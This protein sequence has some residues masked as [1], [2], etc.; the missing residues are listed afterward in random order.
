MFNYLEFYLRAF[1]FENVVTK[2]TVNASCD[3]QGFLYLTK[4]CANKTHKEHLFKMSF[5]TRVLCL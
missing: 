1:N 3:K 4:L 2:P 5:V